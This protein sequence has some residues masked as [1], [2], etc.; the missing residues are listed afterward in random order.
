MKKP[1]MDTKF[2]LSNG[3]YFRERLQ[4]FPIAREFVSSKLL[5]VCIDDVD[6]IVGV[7]GVR[8]LF[9][10]AVSYVR[11]DYRGRGIGTRQLKIA[12]EAAEK[13]PPYFAT[14]TVSSEN[15]VA[16]HVDRKLGF[17]EVL[18]LKKTRQILMV[19]YNT[20]MGRLACASFRVIGHLL[21][22]NIWSYVHWRLYEKSLK[23]R[24]GGECY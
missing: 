23:G 16:L 2:L 20:R 4:G 14:G 1:R 11:K 3:E 12:I 17:R 8:S 7:C 24:V 15:V 5:V 13:R 10:I 21:P 9:N 22:N 6:K 19:T 18:F